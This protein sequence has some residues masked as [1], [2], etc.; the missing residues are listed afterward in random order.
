M[1]FETREPRG[2]NLERLVRHDRIWVWGGA[3]GKWAGVGRRCVVCGVYGTHAK[4]RSMSSESSA[5]DMVDSR[6]AS[7]IALSLIHI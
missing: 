5:G 3:V 7:R 1:A 4:S 6:P 2:L